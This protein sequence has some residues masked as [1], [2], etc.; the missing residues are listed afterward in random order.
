MSSAHQVRP[1]SLLSSQFINGVYIPSALLIVGVGIAKTEW[2]PYAIAISLVLGGWKIYSAGNSIAPPSQS[3]TNKIE[4]ANECGCTTAPETL[5]L[6]PKN[7]VAAKSLKPD[8]F[9][10]FTLKEKTVLSHNTA[11]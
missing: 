3:F 9:Q 8:V 11:M 7:A 6:A 2:L 5:P 1:T 10:D 4:D